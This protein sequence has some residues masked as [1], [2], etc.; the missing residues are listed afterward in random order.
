[1]QQF[2]HMA[3]LAPTPVTGM[4]TF[5]PYHE[6]TISTNAA[7][8]GGAPWCPYDPDGNYLCVCLT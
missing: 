7:L 8:Y 3:P 2:G 4:E 1:M 5:D 6:P